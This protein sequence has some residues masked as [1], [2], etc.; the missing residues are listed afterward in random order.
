VVLAYTPENFMRKLIAVL[1]VSTAML[2]SGCVVEPVGY[3]CGYYHC[4]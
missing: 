3:H 1:M 4:R 2:V